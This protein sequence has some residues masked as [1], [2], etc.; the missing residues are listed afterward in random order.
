MYILGYDVLGTDGG[1]QHT[2]NT[3]SISTEWRIIVGRVVPVKL[4][5]LVF[6]LHMQFHNHQRAYTR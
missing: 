2:T 5:Q 4:V 6:Q 1:R 3:K